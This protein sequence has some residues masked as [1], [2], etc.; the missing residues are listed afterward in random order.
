M[1]ISCKQL[2]S[3]DGLLG[4]VWLAA[5]YEKK[6]S[7]QQFLETNIV[8]SSHLIQDNRFSGNEV[9]NQN[10]LSFRISSQLLLGI[11]KIYLKKTKYLL[12]DVNDVFL[13]L[14]MAFNSM[15]N[16]FDFESNQ[17]LKINKKPQETTLK[18][19][20]AVTLS[21]TL[22]DLDLLYQ[23]NLNLIQEGFNDYSNANVINDL[24][25]DE[26]IEFPRNNENQN[27][28]NN[29]N[30]EDIDLMLDIESN[31]SIEA[32]RRAI[33]P[34]ENTNISSFLNLNYSEPDLKENLNNTEDVL[35]ISSNLG[36]PLDTISEDE[37]IEN[38][39]TL[40]SIGTTLNFS[41]SISNQKKKKKTLDLNVKPS[42]KRKIIIDTS[43]DLLES[44]FSHE[45]SVNLSEKKYLTSK[46]LFSKLNCSKKLSIVQNMASNISNKRQKLLSIDLDIQKKLILSSKNIEN[47]ITLDLNQ[48]GMEID[49]DF[50]YD[51]FVP[52]ITLENLYHDSENEATPTINNETISLNNYI[53]LIAN[54]LKKKFNSEDKILFSNLVNLIPEFQ[55]ENQT[56]STSFLTNDKTNSM[57]INKKKFAA[58]CFFDVLLL[59]TNNYITLKQEFT[60]YNSVNKIEIFQKNIASMD[61]NS[62]IS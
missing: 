57:T 14:K 28:M 53:F 26:S 31:D 46:L 29:E 35:N 32:E 2:I 55:T 21:D 15:R 19:I 12:D 24:N 25:F 8:E 61:F 37:M 17:N 49:N 40:T 1:S 11:V 38:N 22:C 52:S 45:N 42:H 3:K 30:T 23:N 56:E 36:E 34:D 13:R 50:D 41:K 54:N 9:S 20:N 47:E 16:D 51:D 10:A 44:F 43:Q 18:N 7:K 39:N 33:S 4:H 5:N 62:L 48:S 58:E 27:F 59:A 60:D 6:L